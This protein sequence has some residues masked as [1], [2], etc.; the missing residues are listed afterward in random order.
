MCCW[1]LLAEILEAF[2][3][4]SSEVSRCLWFSL[5]LILVS[6]NACLI[7]WEVPLLIHFLEELVSNWQYFFH[8]YLENFTFEGSY[9]RRFL[10]VILS[11]CIAAGLLRLV[12]LFEESHGTF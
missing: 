12:S 5:C 2:C 1:V 9:V 6:G 7:K 3:L 10:M 8:K 11:H 4:R